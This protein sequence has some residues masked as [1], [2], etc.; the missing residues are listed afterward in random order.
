MDNKMKLFK[1]KN[2]ISAIVEAKIAEE[3]DIE[4]LSIL[5]DNVYMAANAFLSRFIDRCA[6]GLVKDSCEHC[7]D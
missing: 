6:E 3:F 1:F 4:I 2:E 5:N 7:G